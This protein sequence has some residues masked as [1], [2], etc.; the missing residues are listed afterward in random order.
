MWWGVICTQYTHWPC[1]HY[2]HVRAMWWGVICTQYTHWPCTHYTHVR[3][4]NKRTKSLTVPFCRHHWPSAL[5]PKRHILIYEQSTNEVTHSGLFVCGHAQEDHEHS[6]MNVPQS[7][8]HLQW[9]VQLL[10]V[11]SG[12]SEVRGHGTQS[13]VKLLLHVQ[14]M[15]TVIWSTPDILLLQWVQYQLNRRLFCG[16]HSLHSLY[17]KCTSMLT[18]HFKMV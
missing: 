16:F 9:K 2:T 14:C 4:I 18:Q 6:A 10:I 7:L 1:T 15:L 17:I 8:L 12:R 3:A 11:A 13:Q 5:L